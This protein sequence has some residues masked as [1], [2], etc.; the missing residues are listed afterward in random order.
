M[1]VL[2]SIGLFTAVMA[3]FAVQLRM[4]AGFEK[5]MPIGHEYIQTFQKYRSDLLGANRITVVVRARKGSIWTKEGLTRLYKVTQA[6]TYLPNVDRIGVQSLWTPNAYVNEI[7]DEGFRAEPIISGTTIM[8]RRCVRTTGGFSFGCAAF[9]ALRSFLMRA[10]GLR[11]RPR[12]KRL[13]ARACTSLT[14]SSFD[15]S[16]RSSRSTPRYENL[17]KVLL[18]FSSAAAAAS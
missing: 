18:R 14:K 16:S 10:I 13:R 11:F 7:T 5:Q 12:E 9:L 3:F 6:V 8:S 15:M 1:A 4:D 17:R 2:V